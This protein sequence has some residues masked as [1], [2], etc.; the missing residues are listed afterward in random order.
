MGG[1]GSVTVG[2]LDESVRKILLTQADKMVT[3]SGAV[4][5]AARI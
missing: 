2:L 4:T 3:A 1:E 5:I